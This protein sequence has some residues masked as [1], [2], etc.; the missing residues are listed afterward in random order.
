[1]AESKVCA[2][3]GAWVQAGAPACPLCSTTTE[4]ARSKANVP[5]RVERASS[6]AAD[7]SPAREVL[8]S[9]ARGTTPY[10]IATGPLFILGYPWLLALHGAQT[11]PGL[12]S[13]LSLALLWLVPEIYL[14]SGVVK[15]AEY[16]NANRRVT[17]GLIPPAISFALQLMVVPLAR[18]LMPAAA[19]A[20]SVWWMSGDL[21]MRLGPL[22]AFA[23]ASVLAAFIAANV[24]RVVPG[25]FGRTIGPQLAGLSILFVLLML[26]S[27]GGLA[28]IR[29]GLNVG[30]PMLWVNVA[31]IFI[32]VF[33]GFFWFQSKD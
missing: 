12:T 30:L 9:C 24:P 14:L 22:T 16:A 7:V 13:D 19:S 1:M 2:N 23:V 18:R 25:K 15:A 26:P 21:L 27:F 17:L 5:R 6:F 11:A 31:A 28:L 32:F 3:C 20:V 33:F 4:D 29:I 8:R 10:A